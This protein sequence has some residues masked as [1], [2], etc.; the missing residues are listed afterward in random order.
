MSIMSEA[1]R[2]FTERSLQL[3]GAKALH[4]LQNS[5]VAVF[6]VGGVGSWAAEA[7]AR[8]GLGTISL[9]D[10]DSIE[11]TNLNR[12]LMALHSTLGA[13]KVVTLAHRF[14]DINP[15]IEVH[16]FPEWYRYAE[17]QRI[18]RAN[19]YVDVVLDCLDDLQAKAELI[20]YCAENSLPILSAGGCGRRL[21][22]LQ[23]Q[24]QLI[25][26]TAG[27]PLLKKLRK[28][29]RAQGIENLVVVSSRE[30]IRTPSQAAAGPASAI[31]VPAS[32]GLLMASC[33]CRH[34]TGEK[35]LPVPYKKSTGQK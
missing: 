30:T 7:L 13:S 20:T 9:V 4:K 2:K 23:L 25:Y 14:R 24:V 5:H 6:G 17:S 33:A 19:G 21:D 22:P 29:L 28:I 31:F 26:E 11:I 32:C 18:L 8:T 27:D 35:E 16:C 1:A 15:Q 3:L 34:I 12:Q 10:G